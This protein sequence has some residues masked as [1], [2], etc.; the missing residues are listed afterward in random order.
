MNLSVKK[1]PTRVLK[2]RCYLNDK[3]AILPELLLREITTMQS[4]KKIF[5]NGLII[6]GLSLGLTVS[7][8]AISALDFE[9]DKARALRGNSFDQNYLGYYYRDGKGVRQD[10]AEAFYWFKKA[11]D[12]GS[13]S[14]Q[15]N[16]GTAYVYGQGVRK[17]Y[18]EAFKWYQKAANRNN[19]Y[20]Q[21]QIG[22]MYDSGQGVSQNKTLAKEWYGK[23]CDNGNQYGCDLYRELNEQGH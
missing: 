7:A 10:Y 17:D 2:N 14:G 1:S 18:D 3:A 16:V 13:T 20:A 22:I 6:F 21:F 15:I 19:R 4:L 9:E 8:A 12:Q 23:A 5:T 11:A